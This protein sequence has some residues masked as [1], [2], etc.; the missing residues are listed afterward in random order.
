M[1]EDDEPRRTPAR[2]T[3]LPLDGLGVSELESYIAELRTEI[4]RA[5]AAIEAK[6]SHR[7]AA[8]LFFKPRPEDTP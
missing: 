6:R 1:I 2:L 3:I 5:E 8:D 4:A 7:G